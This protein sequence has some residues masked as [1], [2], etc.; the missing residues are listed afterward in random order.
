M[1]ITEDE[2]GSWHRFVALLSCGQCFKI[3]KLRS[4]LLNVTKTLFII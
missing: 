3:A 4:H 2:E 1:E